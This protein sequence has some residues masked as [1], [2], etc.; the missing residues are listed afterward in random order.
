MIW[1]PYEQMKTMKPPYEIV[2]AAGVY[3]YTKEG[4][5]MI[6]SIS[7][8]WSVIHGYRHRQLP[9]P[10]LHAGKSCKSR[11]LLAH[12]DIVFLHH[13][14]GMKA[15]KNTKEGEKMIDSISSWWSVIH[16]Y[17]HPVLT[18]AIKEQA[19]VFSHVMLGG[20]TH[21]R[22]NMNHAL[23]AFKSKM[24]IF[25]IPHLHRFEGIAVVRMGERE[26]RFA[27]ILPVHVILQS[28]LQS[29][30]HRHCRTFLC[31]ARR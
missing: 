29:H 5:K 25:V 11:Q 6:D 13:I 17:K 9:L 7:S 3:L 27:L 20:L 15:V 18:R 8:W 22:G 2:D 21:P 23:L 26:H 28:H 4:E 31:S 30:F 14:A 1:Y 16:G 19:D 12:A 24:I 10:L